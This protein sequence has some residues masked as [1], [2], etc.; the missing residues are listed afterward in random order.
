MKKH[1]NTGG[2]ALVLAAGLITACK[3]RTRPEDSRKAATEQNEKKLEA[4]SSQ[5]KAAFAVEAASGNLAGIKLAQLAIARS[6][7]KEIKD[8][9]RT[10]EADHTAALGELKEIA[11]VKGFVLP[12]DE[13]DKT[14][15]L[16]KDLSKDPPARFDRNW[17]KAMME[18]HEKMISRYERALND[19]KDEDLIAWINKLLPRLRIHHD[20]L[21]VLHSQL[22]K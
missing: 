11:G 1:L 5:A 18:K 14:K 16:I 8:I 9:A 20:K 7:N 2:L 12:T 3:D 17:V 6:S 21:M 22:P 19:L 15:D 10:I 13:P 4:D